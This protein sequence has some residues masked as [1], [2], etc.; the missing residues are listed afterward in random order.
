MRETDH[1]TRPQR[2]EPHP[3]VR[4]QILDYF[5]SNGYVV[6]GTYLRADSDNLWFAE[7]KRPHP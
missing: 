7:S 5:T 6:L 1:P 2:I 4:Q 3:E